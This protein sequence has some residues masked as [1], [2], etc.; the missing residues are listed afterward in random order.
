MNCTNCGSYLPDGSMFCTAC[1]AP[2][3]AKPAAAPSPAIRFGRN[4]RSDTPS[5]APTPPPTGPVSGSFASAPGPSAPTPPPPPAFD[6]FPDT[7]KT[8]AFTEYWE[9]SE[10]KPSHA[11]TA[12]R[13]EGRA[14]KPIVRIP[15]DREIKLLLRQGW[16]IMKGDK[17]NL[18]ISL[19]FPL[20]AAIITI[21]I[22]GEYM[23]ITRESTNS[24]CFI[25]VCAAIWGGL[26]NSIQTVVKERDNIK[27]DYVSGALRISS[28]TISRSLLQL[29]LCLFQSAVLSLSFLGIEIFW[30]GNMPSE[31][32]ILPWPTIEYFITLFLLMYAADAM[33]LMISCFV[34][35][36]ELAGKLAP[37][38]LIVQLLFSGV[39]FTMDGFSSILSGLMISRW[40]MEGLGS[41]SN[42]NAIPRTIDPYAM[43]TPDPFDSMYEHEVWHLL[44]VWLILLVFI[45]VPLLVGNRL[46]YNVKNDGRE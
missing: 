21:W 28:Y 41:I 9:A 22:A 38:I 35:K 18:I 44:L 19:L 36:E 30:D 33:G 23:F 29:V 14:P 31:G 15:V 25:L 45:A 6:T 42:L 8:V 13:R 24:G 46:L 10:K 26:F 16:L 5:A 40:G 27:R 17:R 39:L 34:K 12:V 2:V 43:T 1:G 20:I 32:M 7:G 3:A 11:V 37:Y 4:L